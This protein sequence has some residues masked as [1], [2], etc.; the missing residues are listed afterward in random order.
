[1]C[2]LRALLLLLLLLLLLCYLWRCLYQQYQRKT[3]FDAQLQA[4][5]V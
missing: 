3:L 1:V 2:S 5:A 4:L